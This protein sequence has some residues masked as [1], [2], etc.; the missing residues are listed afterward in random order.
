MKGGSGRAMGGGA[1]PALVTAT[2]VLIA[3]VGLT[4]WLLNGGLAA[5][6][7]AQA[8][9]GATLFKDPQTAVFFIGGADRDVAETVADIPAGTGLGAFSITIFFNNQI[10][11]VSVSEGPFLSSTGRTTR[12]FN[13]P[14]ESFVTFS[15]VSMG[16]Q[17][18]PTGSGVLALISV[19]PDP[20][21]QLRPTLNNG[22]ITILDNSSPDAV[23]SDPL[24]E[25]V[26]VGQVRDAVVFVRALE[27][28][29][30]K[31]CIV[32]VIDEQMISYRYNAFFG[33]LL[34]GPT[35]GFFDL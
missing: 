23:L 31:D 35:S 25:D 12:C 18:G 11:D 29:L 28:D 9:G 15:C 10:V 16:S 8:P 21:L 14:F 27:G 6:Y 26:P 24:G 33:S 30:N 34:Y 32:D 17:P 2:G 1:K 20:G 3:L 7:V 5:G 13:F 22:V 19:H 4:A